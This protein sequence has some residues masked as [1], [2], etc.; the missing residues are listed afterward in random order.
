VSRPTQ[1]AQE[2]RASSEPFARLLD[3]AAAEAGSLA[4]AA[5]GASSSPQG[6]LPP[7]PVAAAAAAVAP[8]TTDELLK[9][10]GRRRSSRRSTQL[11]GCMA[12]YLASRPWS[13]CQRALTAHI[14]CCLPPAITFPC[15]SASGGGSGR[16]CRRATC[17]GPP[18]AARR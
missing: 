1:K 10:S 5:A 2:A 9:V 13:C 6:S 18:S 14:V 4:A 17:A 3:T 12:L 15:R 16:A 7:S 8:R 11:H